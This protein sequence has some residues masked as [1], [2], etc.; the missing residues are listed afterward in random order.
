MK[1][2]VV[3]GLGI[4]SPIG[5]NIATYAQSLRNGL[6]GVGPITRFD[7]DNFKAKLAAEVKG[8][9]PADYGITI[10][11]ARHL[12][13]FALY[14]LAAAQQAVAESGI[15]GRVAPER[16]GV[17]VGSGI[18]GMTTFVNETK[19][20][21]EKGPDRVSP[22]FIPM[23]I[24]NIAAGHIAMRY[25]A[26]GPALPIVS[27]CATSTNAIGEAYR[28]IGAGYADAIIAGGA[29]ATIVPLGVAGFINCQALSL[30]Q[31]PLAASI[32]F[33]KR[34]NGFVMGEGAGILVLEE[35]EHA[36]ER[37]APIY[38]EIC[39][40]GNT[41]DAYHVTA[42]R[43]DG[44]TSAMAI[45]AAAE[46]AGLT[47]KDE[48]YINAHGTSTQ[49]NDLTE[50]VAIK[51]A[52]GEERARRARISSTKSMT[53]HMLGAAGA[54]EAIACLLAIKEGFIPPTIGYREADAACDLD[55][56]PNVAV[57]VRPTL[58][59]STSLGFGGHNA[60]VAFRS[61]GE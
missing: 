47:D 42:P 18:G 36:L 60:T 46:E 8:F 7:T 6:C 27:A 10:K 4:L 61:L 40:Y 59:L 52:L 53:G 23:L 15:V 21:L 2:V 11:E 22:F 14:A 48:L 24:G 51:I 41:S 3:T 32:P 31:D 12:D 26:Q 50:T 25:D 44:R 55:Y 57:E 43:P 39:G 37:G 30:S 17:Y 28:A 13:L 20:L 54:A 16:L 5:L 58:A 29:E 19:K 35:M 9:A 49:L 1:R 38:G 33:D 34:R 56:T 45:K